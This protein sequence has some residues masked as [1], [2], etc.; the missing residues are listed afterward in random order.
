MTGLEKGLPLRYSLLHTTKEAF[1]R[2]LPLLAAALIAAPA[3]AFAQDDGCAKFKWSILHEREL[4]KSPADVGASGEISL[5]KG[6]RVALA[7]TDMVH[8]A[9]APERAPKP[10]SHAAI[11]M[12]KIDQAGT[13][14]VTLSD[15][16]W[17]DVV[18]GSVVVKS[19]DFSGARECAGVRKSVR[20]EL[21]AGAATLQ[22]SN[23]DAETIEVAV[24]PAP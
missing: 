6:F 7:A 14:D 9:A 18:A 12:L 23:I 19:S 1:M 11:L 3:L 15:E 10:T 17:I 21:I 20:F 2:I 24:V 16:G 5:G 22:L 4:M 13:Y 8:F